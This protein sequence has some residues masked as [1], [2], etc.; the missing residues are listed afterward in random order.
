VPE[1]LGTTS[2]LPDRPLFDFAERHGVQKCLDASQE[3][4]LRHFDLA[5]PPELSLV[6]DPDTEE[7]WVE[8]GI[9]VRGTPEQVSAAYS[10]YTRDRLA[11]CPVE[12]C[13]LVR[14]AIRIV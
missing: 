7:Q 9:R 3:L 13:L 11:S 4:T 12:R 14:L 8:I 1:I 10:R 5:C 6:A 2:V